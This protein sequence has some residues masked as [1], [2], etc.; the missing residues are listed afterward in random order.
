[1]KIPLPIEYRLLIACSRATID[2]DQ[3]EHI[4]QLINASPDWN[5]LILSARRHGLLLLLHRT[6]CA[7][8]QGFVPTVVMEQLTNLAGNYRRRNLV[9]VAEL[10]RIVAILEKAGIEAIP[11][12]GPALAQSV[13]QDFALREFVDLDFLV[14][15]R[16]AIRTR[17]A[18][19]SAGISPTKSVSRLAAQL[20]RFFHCEFSFVVLGEVKLEIN[21]RL[22]PMYWR[23]PQIDDRIWERHARL[24]LAGVDTAMLDTADLLIVLCVHGCKHIWVMLKWIVDIADLLRSEPQLDW[25]S[26]Q[27]RAQ[28]MGAEI[29]LEIGLVLAHEVL[30]APVPAE[31][32]DRVRRRTKT[33]ALVNEVY[34]RAFEENHPPPTVHEKLS[35]AARASQNPSGKVLPYLLM[36][37]YFILHRLVRPGHAMLS[38]MTIGIS[39]RSAGAAR[40]KESG[41][42]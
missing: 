23:L 13:Y 15:P 30:G 18:L 31:I 4:E 28:E 42:N 26:L 22:A 21:W 36:P 34:G 14:R 12:K 29:M 11:Y 7:V 33:M 8:G 32:L 38:K 17:Q 19:I 9:L 2:V 3:R 37:A 10:L 39:G 6:L 41:I 25:T 1:M 20:H 16:D 35:F 5:R 27:A 24:R 40:K